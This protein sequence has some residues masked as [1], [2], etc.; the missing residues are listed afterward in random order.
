MILLSWLIYQAVAAD[1][2]EAVIPVYP[3]YVT[4]I[5]CEGRLLVSAIGDDRVVRL[6]SLPKDL[7]CGILLKPVAGNGRTNL[8]IETSTGTIERV[9]QVQSSHTSPQAGDLSFVLKGGRP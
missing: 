9:V 8:L 5:Q 7:G 2:P 6:E 3:G 4:R 1:R